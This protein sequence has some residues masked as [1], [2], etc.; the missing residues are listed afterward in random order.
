[1][2]GLFDTHEQQYFFLAFLYLSCSG[3]LLAVEVST[4][5]HEDALLAFLADNIERS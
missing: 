5:P 4:I 1:M 3:K 2:D